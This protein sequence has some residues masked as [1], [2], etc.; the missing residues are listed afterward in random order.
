MVPRISELQQG[1]RGTARGGALRKG[2]LPGCARAGRV[3]GDRRSRLLAE[4]LASAFSVPCFSF[5]HES[6]HIVGAIRKV[7]QKSEKAG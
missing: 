1:S 2:L 7:R 4:R 5:F 6:G 3:E